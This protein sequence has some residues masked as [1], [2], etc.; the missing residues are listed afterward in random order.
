V[1]GERAKCRQPFRRF[2]TEPGRTS[3]KKEGK[4]LGEKRNLSITLKGKETILKTEKGE[5]DI[6]IKRGHGREFRLGEKRE[7]LGRGK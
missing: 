1:E 3:K 4:G 2:S 7:E 6:S 5:V